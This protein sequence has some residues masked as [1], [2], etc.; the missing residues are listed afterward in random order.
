MISMRCAAEPG[1]AAATGTV[2]AQQN[3]CVVAPRLRLSSF[4]LSSHCVDAHE[5]GNHSAKASRETS[6]IR[7][8]R[9]GVA[10]MQC[11]G[12]EICKG[13]KD[14]QATCSFENS[15]INQNSQVENPAP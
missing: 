1:K 11:S 13:G 10:E 4:E 3:R 14:Y 15:W 9:R 2:Y 7:R 6:P 8:R 12:L 5:V